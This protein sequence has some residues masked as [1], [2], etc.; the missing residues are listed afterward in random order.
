M[1]GLDKRGHGSL[2]HW[3]CRLVALGFVL[4]ALVP[5][6][7]MPDFN[8]VHDGSLKLVICTSAG[9]QVVAIGDDGQP[10]PDPAP[11]HAK[12]DCPFGGLPLLAQV[13]AP[14]AVTFAIQAS[15]QDTAF[16]I[17]TPRAPVWRIGPSSG[18]RAPPAFV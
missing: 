4:R 9:L 8:G 15:S 1:I 14:F 12:G 7:Y 10:I 5:L 18:S 16:S 2:H 3:L 17:R 6:G 13:S 11:S